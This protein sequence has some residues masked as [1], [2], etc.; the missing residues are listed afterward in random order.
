MAFLYPLIDSTDSVNFAADS[1]YIQTGDIEVEVVIRIEKSN[2]QGP[3]IALSY[4]DTLTSG[5][6]N[7]NCNI[8]FSLELSSD[9]R[10]FYRHEFGNGIDWTSG[11][12]LSA[13]LPFGVWKRIKLTRIG[14]T[15]TILVDGEVIRTVDFGTAPY[16]GTNPLQTLWIGRVYTGLSQSRDY[17]TGFSIAYAQYKGPTNNILFT[18][19]ED[20]GG[21]P[22]TLAPQIGVKFI[23]A[24]VNSYMRPIQVQ[25]GVIGLDPYAGKFERNSQRGSGYILDMSGAGGGP[26]EATEINPPRAFPLE[27]SWKRA[28]PG[29]FSK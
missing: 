28:N 3:I 24:F 5:N 6:E 4:Q 19:G 29:S 20:P 26:S 16:A 7:P 13:I 22:R 1:K 21:S 18:Y 9:Q 25:K 17:G 14:K 10:P 8:L 12:S 15:I 27:N 2:A 11:S 23:D